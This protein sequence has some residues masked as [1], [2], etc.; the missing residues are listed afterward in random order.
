MDLILYDNPGV[1][2]HT[3]TAQLRA[4]LPNVDFLQVESLYLN[5]IGFRKVPAWV[6]TEFPSLKSLHLDHNYLTTLPDQ[7]GNLADLRTIS[8][9]NNRLTEFPACLLRCQSLKAIRLLK[10][11]IKDFPYQACALPELSQLFLDP[12]VPR[13]FHIPDCL[14]SSQYL[15]EC[16]ILWQQQQKAQHSLRQLCFQQLAVRPAL[17]ADAN[18][19]VPQHLREELVRDFS[20]PDIFAPM[21]AAK[22]RRLE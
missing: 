14:T 6:Y 20:A 4:L 8:L 3:T 7:L 19:R 13:G 22:K 5:C 12:D 9:N 17:A 16:K 2:R 10:N 18:L 11:R 21:H 1:S 15:Y